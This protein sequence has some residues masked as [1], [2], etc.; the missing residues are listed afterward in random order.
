[1]RIILMIMLLYMYKSTEGAYI[2]HSGS[3]MHRDILLLFVYVASDARLYQCSM[4]CPGTRPNS[5][6]GASNYQ[7]RDMMRELVPVRGNDKGG[8]RRGDDG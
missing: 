7:S 5:D 2:S 4:G 8:W 1:M 6:R 3:K